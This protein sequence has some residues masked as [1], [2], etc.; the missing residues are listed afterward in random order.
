MKL[1]EALPSSPAASPA[2]VDSGRGTMAYRVFFCAIPE[3]RRAPTT[4]AQ[5]QGFFR[6]PSPPVGA[7]APDASGQ[8]GALLALGRGPVRDAA[9]RVRPCLR[10]RGPRGLPWARLYRR[11]G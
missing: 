3:N 1:P 2:R 7:R 11:G 6:L 8:A 5:N 9:S 10:Q 4:W